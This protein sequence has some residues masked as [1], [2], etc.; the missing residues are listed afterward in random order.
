MMTN[1]RPLK[2]EEKGDSA[3][4]ICFELEIADVECNIE[5]LVKA[6][7]STAVDSK[8]IDASIERRDEFQGE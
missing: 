5:V 1:F 4:R 2:L 3:L 6:E 8:V 7:D